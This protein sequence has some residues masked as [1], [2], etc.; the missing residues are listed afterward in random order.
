[1]LFAPEH[2]PTAMAGGWKAYRA[3]LADPKRKTRFTDWKNPELLPE[4]LADLSSGEIQAL[5]E[6]GPGVRMFRPDQGTT[7]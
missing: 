2:P 3:L 7:T 1:M 5:F 6:Y 4:T